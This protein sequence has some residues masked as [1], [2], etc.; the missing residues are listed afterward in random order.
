MNF[1]QAIVLGIVQG[2]TE[3]LPVSSSGHLEI[4][5][6]FMG[7]DD[8][9]AAFSAIIQIGT[10]LAVILY[11]MKDIKRIFVAWA[12]SVSGLFIR[13]QINIF[14]ELNKMSQDAK[15][16]WYIVFG[17]IPIVLAGVFLKSLIENEF[18]TLFLTAVVLIVFGGLL[19]LVDYKFASKRKLRDLD[20][21][22][23]LWFGIAQCLALI[24]GVSRSG[25]TITMGRFLGFDRRSCAKFSFYLAI[26]SV[27][28]SALLEVVSVF[29]HGDINSDLF[30]GWGVTCVAT[31]ISFV[32]GYLV[33]AVF[34]K[35]INKISFAPFAIYRIVFG[36]LVIVLLSFGV[37]A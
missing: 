5:S 6:K 13:R 7:L 37:I 2:L 19:W 36:V 27:F 30:P 4:V 8:A 26:P 10:E 34:M 18:R 21:K 12:I 16:G 1:F 28:G 33:I 24:P 15:M 3:F 32:V 11:F 20:Q 35:V 9:G 23:A 31:V 22:N 29:K 14:K 25:S 17:T